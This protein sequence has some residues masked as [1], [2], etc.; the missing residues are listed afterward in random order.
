MADRAV[1]LIG[2]GFLVPVYL[3]LTVLWVPMLAIQFLVFFNDG[4][5]RE[6]SDNYNSHNVSYATFMH[7]NNY[8]VFLLCSRYN[9]I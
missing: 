4:H 6:E 9:G 8:D 3:L 5:H 1:G 7:T 2:W